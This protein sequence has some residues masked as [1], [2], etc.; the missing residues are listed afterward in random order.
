MKFKLINEKGKLFGFINLIDLIVLLVIAVVAVVGVKFVTGGGL[1]ALNSDDNEGFEGPVTT[2]EMTFFAEEV[3]DFVAD[4]LRNG[5]YLYDESSLEKLGELTA[6]E[7]G[8]SVLFYNDDE[9]KSVASEKS[10]YSSL[11]I[12]G[13]VDGERT[14]LGATVGKTHYA[15]GHT[16]V[17]R[18]GDTK[19]YLR[20]YD[21]MAKQRRLRRPIE[22]Q[23]E[24]VAE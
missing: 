18:A 11:F 24:Y 3:S 21:V 1:A 20:A 7:T 2:L 15:A 8:P 22:G 9:G 23:P 14:P 10:T 6:F 19:I 16:F 12:K 17:L 13:Q 4:D 5:A